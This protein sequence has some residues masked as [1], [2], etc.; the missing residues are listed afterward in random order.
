MLEIAGAAQII[1]EAGGSIRC[2]VSANGEEETWE[3]TLG[4]GTNYETGV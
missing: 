3:E 4:E 2:A 1:V